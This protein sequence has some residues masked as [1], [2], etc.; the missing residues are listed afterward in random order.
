MPEIKVLS[1]T[2]MKMVF[3][4]LSPRF[5]RETGNRL[6]VTLGPSLA[7]E[8]RVGEDEAELFLMF[9]DGSAAEWH[10]LFLVK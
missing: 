2:A 6:A 7:L 10:Y 1:T 8:K 4:E 3:E 5:E 9:P